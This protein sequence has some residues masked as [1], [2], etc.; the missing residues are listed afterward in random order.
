M[1]GCRNGCHLPPACPSPRRI[2]QRLH[3]VLAQAVLHGTAPMSTLQPC[4]MPWDALAVRPSRFADVM[5]R[6]G[7][8][9]LTDVPRCVS[10]ACAEAAAAAAAFFALDDAVKRAA[11]CRDRDL[12]CGYRAGFGHREHYHIRC[13][14]GARQ[15][16]PPG[17]FAAKLSHCARG[18]KGVAEQCLDAALRQRARPTDTHLLGPSVLDAFQYG[19]KDDAAVVLGGHH[20]PGYLTLEPRASAPGLQVLD[21]NEE[22]Q[23]V[24]PA[25]GAGDLVVFAGDAL[26]LATGRKVKSCWH[27]VVGGQRPRLAL[28]FEL[29]CLT[30]DAFNIVPSPRPQ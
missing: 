16:W 2:P 20:D 28:A 17:D 25:M 5:E 24:E 30:E 8:V 22:W 7:V 15:P 19:P 3:T 12:P 14:A 21:A 1:K 10:T 4:L 6:H 27:R 23:P 11:V 13:D 9:I 18:L 29:R 26:Q